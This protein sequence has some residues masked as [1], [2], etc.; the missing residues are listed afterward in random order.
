MSDAVADL[1]AALALIVSIFGAVWAA[2]Q[3]TGRWHRLERYGNVL[4]AARPGSLEQ[5]AL[6]SVFDRL[7]LPLALGALA[8]PR[9]KLRRRAWAAIYVGFVIETVWILMVAVNQRG[10]LPWTVYGIGLAVLMTGVLLRGTWRERR[11]RWMREEM[12]RRLV[13]LPTTC[14][15]T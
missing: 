8:P 9:K 5:T 13:Q 1:I 7:A 4:Q 11:Q 14:K 3:D 10:G 6:Q 2:Y 12:H 15:L